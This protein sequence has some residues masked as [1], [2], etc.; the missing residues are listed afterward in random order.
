MTFVINKMNILHITNQLDVG[1]ITSY[2]LTLGTGFKKRAHSVFIASSGGEIL[3]RFVK[4]GMV[5]I[6][7]PIKTKSEISPKVLICLN[8]LLTAARKNKID[9]IHSHSRT[10]Q[11]L[12]FLLGRL[13]GIPYLS[14]CHGFFKRRFSR[15]VCPCWGRKVIAIS[16]Q[17][18]EHLMDDFGVKENDIRVIHNGIDTDK[19]KD[20][21]DKAGMKNKFG[22]G[23]F[24][25][26]GIIARLSDVK[27][28]IYLI[29]AMK[30]VIKKIPD[31]RLFIVGEGRM[32]AELV[33]LTKR[34]G[35]E[36]NIVF[37]PD[38]DDT[39][40]ALAAMDIFVM[41]SLNEGLGLALM[42]AMSCGLAVVGSNVGGIKTLIQHGVNGLLVE[43]KDETGL[44]SA[45]LEL[46]G[47]SV[48]AATL[49]NTAKTFINDNFSQEKMVLETERVYLECL[50]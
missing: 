9:I 10:T 28:H 3:P 30:F 5:F 25:V 4:E 6:P 20:L 32:K 47:D 7:I 24:P 49:G 16:R 42:E 2:V 35:L 36:K 21:E 18:K 26:I 50:R 39:R 23:N 13:T 17:V 37:T 45:I 40:D 15:R 38:V 19:F 44:S 8:R 14:T 34:L 12:G 33:N 11:V 27:G 41:P 48:K 29:G 22:L 31:A 1:G 46:L 43:P